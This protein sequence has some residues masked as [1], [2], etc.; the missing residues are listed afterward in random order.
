M[1]MYMWHHDVV[2]ITTAQFRS[3][4]PELRLCTGC[5]PACCM[6]EICNGEGL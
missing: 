1:Y 5:N 6:S 4:K 2:V 3:I